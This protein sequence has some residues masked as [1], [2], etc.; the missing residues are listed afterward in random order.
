MSRHI[1]R[2]P[3]CAAFGANSEDPSIREAAKRL[4]RLF[5]TDLACG[6][7]RTCSHEQVHCM[8]PLNMSSCQATQEAFMQ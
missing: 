4:S 1:Q 6:C 8:L 5:Y 2:L 7:S 3:P